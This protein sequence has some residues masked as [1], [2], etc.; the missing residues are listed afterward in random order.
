MRDLLRLSALVKGTYGVGKALHEA[1]WRTPIADVDE[2][3]PNGYSI[4]KRAN[5]RLHSGFEAFVLYCGQSGRLSDEPRLV[6]SEEYRTRMASTYKP[7]PDTP[8][9]RN[10]VSSKGYLGIGPHRLAEEDLICVFLAAEVPFLLRKL[11]SGTYH[12]VGEC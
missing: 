1:I 5:Y 10:F 7:A 4:L 8:G 11:S 9:R 6:Q 3:R 2:V 12:L